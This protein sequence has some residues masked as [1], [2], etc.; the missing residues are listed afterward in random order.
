MY[1]LSLT[2]EPIWTDTKNK[3][4][5]MILLLI[6]AVIIALSFVNMTLSVVGGLLGFVIVLFVFAIKRRRQR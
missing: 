4:A 3:E 1:Q 5:F 2:L 6:L